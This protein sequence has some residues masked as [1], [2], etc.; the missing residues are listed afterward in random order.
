MIKVVFL[1]S[2]IKWIVQLT[3]KKICRMIGKGIR[4]VLEENK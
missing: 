4:G 2:G 1:I 3:L